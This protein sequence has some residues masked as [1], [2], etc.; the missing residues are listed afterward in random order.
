[1]H[2]GNHNGVVSGPSL[3]AEAFNKLFTQNLFYHTRSV[4]CTNRTLIE[5]LLQCCITALWTWIPSTM[6]DSGVVRISV[7][8][9]LVSKHFF[10]WTIKFLTWS[11]AD[12]QSTRP[13]VATDLSDQSPPVSFPCRSLPVS[14][15]GHHQPRVLAIV[16]ARFL[17]EVDVL[18]NLKVDTPRY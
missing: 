9:L 4:M 7:C 8:Q 6:D 10:T 11:V 12:L 13:Q 15:P 18:N 2:N 3:S 17:G 5:D 1:M 16:P 14:S